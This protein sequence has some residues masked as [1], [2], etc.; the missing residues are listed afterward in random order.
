MD[1]P[2]PAIG[3]P[4]DGHII[5][6]GR[7]VVVVLIQCRGWCWKDVRRACLGDGCRSS[8]GAA[9]EDAGNDDPGSD[10]VIVGELFVEE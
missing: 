9:Q 5:T 10:E 6:A 3:L 8:F 4:A 2:D 7:G 1:V